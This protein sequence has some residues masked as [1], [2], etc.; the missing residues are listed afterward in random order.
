MV[1]PQYYLTDRP[2]QGYI[3]KS[4]CEIGNPMRNKLHLGRAGIGTDQYV[5]SRL[6][7]LQC[8]LR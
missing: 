6:W 1:G 3:F 2:R 4:L 8:V 7:R 5:L